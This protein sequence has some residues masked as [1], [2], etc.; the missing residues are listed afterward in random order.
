MVV[1]DEPAASKVVVPWSLDRWD[2]E[3]RKWL[4]S[5]ASPGT[6]RQYQMTIRRWRVW[7]E[8]SGGDP[9][10]ATRTAINAWREQLTEAD[11]LA[12]KSVAR[13]LATIASFYTWLVEEG[14]LDASPAQHIR[15]PTVGAN[16]SATIALDE[17]ELAKVIRAAERRKDRRDYIALLVL[18]ETGIRS[19]ELIAARFADH[20]IDHGEHVLTV[21]RKGGA[22]DR[23]TMPGWVGDQL[24]RWS[25]RRGSEWI[26][27]TGHPEADYLWL[28]R[29]CERVGLDSGVSKRRP[30]DSIERKLTPHVLRATFAT[31]ALD[32]GAPLAYV[33]ASMGHVDPRTT[34]LYDR[35][36]GKLARQMQVTSAVDKHIPRPKEI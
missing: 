24:D 20:T 32:E 21:T 26:V 14:V 36:R 7:C 25:T 13:M 4:L 11:D 15:R 28:W 33:Q 17:R 29:M 10:S 34:G 31:V 19:R 27:G 8:R 6:R 35:G 30:D 18:A 16:Y 9:F 5:K 3:V 23:V 22:Q 1:V 12:P 2:A